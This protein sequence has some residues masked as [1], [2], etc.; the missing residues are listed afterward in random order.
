MAGRISGLAVF[1]ATA[2]GILLWSG[3]KGQTTAQTI[4][5]IVGGNSA[6]LSQ[7]GSEG[8]TTAADTTASASPGG[9][10]GGD[11]ATPTG[12]S[13]AAGVAAL[14]QAAHPYGW[15]TGS[16]WTALNYV[17][18]REAGYNPH[19]K[20]PTSGAYGMAQALGHGSAAT[21][22]TESDQYGGYGLTD[23]Q[24]KQAN[25]GSAYWQSVWMVNYIRST[26]GDPIAA[27]NHERANNWY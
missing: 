10:G 27:A 21:A 8:I 25:S 18:M 22:G 23:A 11:F 13:G 1:Y 16:E 26:Y 7:Q 14:K 9:G 5:A 17:E 3:F 12:A 6:A 20:N 4:K 2:G 15:D 24:A 19:A